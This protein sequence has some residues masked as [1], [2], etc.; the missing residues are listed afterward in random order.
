[1]S[2]DGETQISAAIS[3]CQVDRQWKVRY[4]FGVDRSHGAA[5]PTWLFSRILCAR[6]SAILY[7]A[8]I[9]RVWPR[10]VDDRPALI[11]QEVLNCSRA[12]ILR[13]EFP[14]EIA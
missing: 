12:A 9:S 10:G 11:R 14:F 13:L 8:G 7:E 6:H 5:G 2:F 4:Y 3:F 1:M